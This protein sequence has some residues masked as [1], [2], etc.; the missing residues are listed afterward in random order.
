MYK[1]KK[2]FVTEKN[3]YSGTKNSQNSSIKGDYQSP[4]FYRNKYREDD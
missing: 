1:I 4:T 3:P 2:E